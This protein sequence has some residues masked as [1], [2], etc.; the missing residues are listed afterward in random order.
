MCFRP[1]GLLEDVFFKFFLLFVSTVLLFV[2][3]VRR[4][5]GRKYLTRQRCVHCYACVVT[6]EIGRY[7]S[8]FTTWRTLLILGR[9][10]GFYRPHR[11]RFVYHRHSSRCCYCCLE[12]N[13]GPEVRMGSPNARSVVRKGHWYRSWSHRIVST[14]W[15]F[16]NPGFTRTIQMRLRLVK[17]FI[18]HRLH[19]GACVNLVLLTYL[20]CDQSGF[21]SRWIPAWCTFHARQPHIEIE[22]GDCSSY[23]ATNWR[24]GNIR[25][26]ARSRPWRS[27]VSCCRFRMLPRTVLQITYF[28]AELG[29]D[30]V[31]AVLEAAESNAAKSNTAGA[32]DRQHL[33]PAISDHFF[34]ILRW[35][36]GST[37]EGWWHHWCRQIH[38]VRRL[39]LSRPELDRRR[40][41]ALVVRLSRLASVRIHPHASHLHYQQR[42]R[43]PRRISNSVRIASVEVRS[44]HDVSDH[45][46]VTWSI[47]MQAAAG[48]TSHRYQQFWKHQIHRAKFHAW[49]YQKIESVK[50][51][52]G[53]WL[54]GK[55]FYPVFLG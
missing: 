42:A 14:L 38:H 52:R 4:F 5:L 16:V 48:A 29:L 40:G 2:C 31:W 15:R 54:A 12:S 10:G 24:W 28:Q 1:E 44:S 53:L 34:W 49:G 35:A 20:L 30:V 41:V 17:W 36:L 11:R 22:A 47:T 7:R 46:L 51:S 13:P 25:S 43:S 8:L 3:A 6:S 37:H 18:S 26:S 9:P 32:G 50:R 21:R 45:D 27:N 33:P 55:S 39:Q 23:I 19:T